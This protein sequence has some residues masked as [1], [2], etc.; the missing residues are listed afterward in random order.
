M[1]V[2]LTFNVK[3]ESESFSEEL[4]PIQSDRNLSQTKASLDTYAEW[5]T[6]E[7]INAV[8]SALEIYHNVYLV[9]ADL[10]AY[11]KL[12]DIKPDIVFNIAEGFNG[13]SREAQIPAI[14]DML[15][16]PYTGSDP[17]TLS[18]CLDK[19]RTKEVLSYHKIPT[20]NFIVIDSVEQADN[21]NLQYPL[22]VKPVFEGSSKGIFSS[23]FVK[24]K[25]ELLNE[26]RRILFDY[27]Q[28]ALVEE[29]LPGRE[30]TVAILGNNNLEVLPIVEILYNDF[31]NDFLPIYSYEAKWIFDTRENPLNVFSCPAVLDET[32]KSDIE[33]VVKRTYKV[34]NCK[35]WSRID[36]RLNKNNVPNIIEV[37]PL[38]GI[39][40]N[41]EDNSCFPKAARTAGLSYND[42]INKVL[43]L[44]AK[45][46]NLI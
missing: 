46:Y 26:I 33:N 30:F 21:I 7:T 18:T 24:T 41:P 27:N 39:L 3:P 13:R 31:P 19:A 11:N 45:R 44:A 16:I 9:E 43:F 37:N 23:S 22:F 6:W 42:L 25:S 8:K 38:P 10:N 14:L 2:A 17:L 5:D 29:F 36:V 12:L 40:P 34:L 4:S 32:L 35:D 20:A 1:N 28:S 15:Q